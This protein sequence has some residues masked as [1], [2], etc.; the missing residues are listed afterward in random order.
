VERKETA[1]TSLAAETVS[2]LRH[3]AALGM[4]QAAARYGLDVLE[5]PVQPEV[6]NVTQFVCIGRDADV[7][8]RV[9]K[10]S[11]IITLANRP[12]SL[13]EVLEVFRDHHINMTR[14]LSRPMIGQPKSYLFFVDLEGNPAESPVREALA[15]ARRVAASLRIAGSYPVRKPYVS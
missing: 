3:A 10:T 4:K 14:L 13:C 5:F 12:G 8:G 2:T 1:S 15:R 9:D 11:L 6:P 7:E